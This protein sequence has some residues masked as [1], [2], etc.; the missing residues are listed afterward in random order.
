ML[1]REPPLSTGRGAARTAQMPCMWFAPSSPPPPLAQLRC[2][3]VRFLPARVLLRS[4]LT[5][6]MQREWPAAFA[7]LS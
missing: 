1:M 4:A 7:G 6:P 3:W 2:T 5:C